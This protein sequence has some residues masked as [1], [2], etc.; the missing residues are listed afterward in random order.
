MSLTNHGDNKFVDLLLPGRYYIGAET[1]LKVW[2][3]NLS[4]MPLYVQVIAYMEVYIRD[5]GFWYVEDK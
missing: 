5:N 1:I 2:V 3:S 4:D